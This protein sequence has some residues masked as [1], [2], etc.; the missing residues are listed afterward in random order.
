ME[1]SSQFRLAG[2]GFEA[3][4]V[5]LAGLLEQAP[6]PTARPQNH[7]KRPNDAPLGAARAQS[8]FNPAKS[9]VAPWLDRP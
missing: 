9:C 6:D 3:S 2:F 5:K 7:A 8:A 1:A 4:D